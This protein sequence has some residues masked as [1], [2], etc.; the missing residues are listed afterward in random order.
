M[1]PGSPFEDFEGDTGNTGYF[2]SQ[3]TSNLVLIITHIDPLIFKIQT[4]RMIHMDP[5]PIL[6]LTMR[7]LM[8]DAVNLLHVNQDGSKR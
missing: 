4:S 6:L 5:I 8:F 2:F 3:G 1:T 7:D